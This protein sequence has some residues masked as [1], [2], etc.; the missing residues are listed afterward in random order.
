MTNHTTSTTG[1]SEEL[2]ETFEHMLTVLMIRFGDTREAEFTNIELADLTPQQD[3]DIAKQNREMFEYAKR[4]LAEHDEALFAQATAEA[5]QEHRDF[6][7][8]LDQ[9][10]YVPGFWGRRIDEEY[11]R[12]FTTPTATRGEEK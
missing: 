11:N 1:G 2:R 5:R 10:R 8:E 7:N 4:W 12:L 6:I 9:N 3:E